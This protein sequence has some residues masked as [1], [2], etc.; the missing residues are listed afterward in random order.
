MTRAKLPPSVSQ[1]RLGAELRRMRE[2]ADLSATRAGELFGATQSRISNIEAGGYA[3]SAE[4]VRA[5]ARLYDCDD[6]KLIEALAAMTGGRTRGWWEEY[7]EILPSDALDLAELEYQ[8]RELR[9]SSTIHLPGLLQTREHAR[10]MIS[11]AVPPMRQDEVEHRVSHRLKR[12]SVVH[13]EPPTPLTAIIHEA[14]LRVGFG[15]Q[16]IARAQ[17]RRLIDRSEEPHITLLVV[18][19]STGTY[20]SAGHGIVQFSGPIPSLDTIQL[21]T[22][23]GSVFIDGEA[24]LAKYRKL[25]DRLEAC[26]LEPSKSRNLMTR[27]LRET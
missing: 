3:V 10:A 16:S 19:F 20:P 11:D 23:H 4:R 14:A 25:L 18:P 9:V 21:D 27:I 7:R 24:R 6:E 8:A 1:R 26:A 22:D 15:G 2:H 5:L 17:L 12:Q 13:G